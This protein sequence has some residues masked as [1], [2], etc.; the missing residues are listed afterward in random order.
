MK[1][2]ILDAVPSKYL[3]VD[4]HIS[5][6]SKFIDLLNDVG[7][8]GEMVTFNAGDDQFPPSVETCDAY[9]VGGSPVSVYDDFAWITRLMDFVRQAHSRRMPLVGIC[10]GH[11]LIAQALGGQVELAEGGWLLGLKSFAVREKPVWMHSD[12]ASYQIYHINQDQVCKLPSD[13]VHLGTSDVCE[14]SMFTIGQHVL[15]IQGH[16]EQ[17]LRAMHNF[18]RELGDEVPADVR[19]SAY[20]SFQQAEPDRL[21]VGGWIRRFLEQ[22]FAM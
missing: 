10:F 22:A 19:Q 4:N 15:C 2:G 3:Y 1:L 17:P 5:D 13:A 9:L 7:F 20:V 8:A 12:A 11:Q 6:A 14:F 18:I 16:P 21:I